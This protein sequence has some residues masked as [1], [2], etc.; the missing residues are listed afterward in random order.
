MPKP[1][2]CHKDIY[3]KSLEDTRQFSVD[4]SLMHGRPTFC[5]TGVNIP[6]QEVLLHS[7]HTSSEGILGVYVVFI[8]SHTWVG[9]ADIA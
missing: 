8:R 9:K 1:I 3:E 6:E 7:P 5:N 4:D 2:E